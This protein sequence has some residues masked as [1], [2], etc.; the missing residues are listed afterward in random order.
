MKRSRIERHY[1]TNELI[2][3]MNSKKMTERHQ[4]EWKVNARYGDSLLESQ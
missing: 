4:K 1:E 3:K 2:Y